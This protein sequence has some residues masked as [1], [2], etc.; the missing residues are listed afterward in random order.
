MVVRY[1]VA[2][3]SVALT[4]HHWG[5]PQATSTKRAKQQLQELFFPASSTWQQRTLA[6]GTELVMKAAQALTDG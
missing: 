5:Q 4:S 3:W 1:N 6:Q 2:T